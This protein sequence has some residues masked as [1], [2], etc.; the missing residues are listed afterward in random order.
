MDEVGK[1]R[2]GLL[3]HVVTMMAGEHD[4]AALIAAC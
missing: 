3:A 1:V 2:M 4:A